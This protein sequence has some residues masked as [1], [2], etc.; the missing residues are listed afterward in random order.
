M[1]WLAHSGRRSLIRLKLVYFSGLLLSTPLLPQFLWLFH[2]FPHLDFTLKHPVLHFEHADNT[3]PIAT[4]G[5]AIDLQESQE[6]SVRPFGSVKQYNICIYNAR[7]PAIG[8]NAQMHNYANEQEKGTD[9]S[10]Y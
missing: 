9:K 7:G 8:D 6:A 10:E 4:G 2:S 5:I 3:G 1:L